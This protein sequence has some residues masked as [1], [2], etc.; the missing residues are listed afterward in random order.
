MFL[1]ILTNFNNKKFKYD[2]YINILNVAEIKKQ[3]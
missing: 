3:L 1:D 2:N